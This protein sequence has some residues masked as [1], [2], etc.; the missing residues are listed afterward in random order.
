VVVENFHLQQSRYHRRPGSYSQLGEYAAQV[1][2]HCPGANVQ[3]IG[4]DFIGMSLRHHTDYFLFT[5]AKLNVWNDR[6]WDPHQK[7][8]GTFHFRID[9]HVF[10]SPFT[11]FDDCS[12][13]H[14]SISPTSVLKASATCKSMASHRGSV[15]TL[16]GL[17]RIDLSRRTKKRLFK[18]A[19]GRIFPLEVLDY[20]LNCSFSLRI[21]SAH[22]GVVVEIYRFA[23]LVR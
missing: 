22:L 6:L 11:L 13:A 15:W 2:A 3:N 19:S 7:V 17:M 12:C 16:T 21:F 1:R 14:F 8:T 9:Q 5:R 23:L 18:E 20:L 10:R 4:D